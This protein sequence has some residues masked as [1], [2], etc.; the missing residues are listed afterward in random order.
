MR[1]KAT[2]ELQAAR[3]NAGAV[4]KYV[5]A[6]RNAASRSLGLSNL[7]PASPEAVEA[8]SMLRQSSLCLL[9]DQLGLHLRGPERAPEHV[10]DLKVGQQSM[11][12]SLQPQRPR[13]SAVVHHEVDAAPSA[14]QVLL[15]EDLRQPPRL[16]LLELAIEVVA[17]PV[18]NREQRLQRLLP[19]RQRQLRAEHPADSA[20]HE[21]PV[22]RLREPQQ[23]EAAA[24]AW[25]RRWRPSGG[26]GRRRGRPGSPCSS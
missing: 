8:S 16:V 10:Q 22:A 21:P 24:C 9:V 2:E 12:A 19:L 11:V 1:R 13:R 26:C 25:R 3:R 15:R 23:I 6:A 4:A 20:R 14:P 7:R 17:S 18:E 5:T